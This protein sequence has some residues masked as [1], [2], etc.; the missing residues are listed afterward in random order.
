MGAKKYFKVPDD[1]AEFIRTAHPQL[2][3]KTERYL[4]YETF[5]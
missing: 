1:V 5:G 2:K 4:P 3:K